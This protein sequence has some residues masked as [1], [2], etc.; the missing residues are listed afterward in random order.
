VGRNSELIRQ[1]TILQQLAARR[2]ATITA[3]ATDLNVTTRTVRRDLT[4]LQ[5]CGFPIYDDV[6]NGTKFWRL[7][8]KTLIAAL[9]RD[10]LTL[11]EFC[12]L[13]FSRALVRG[14]AGT[15]LLVDLQSALDK[16]EAAF[17]A[18][19]KK[20]LDRLP[21]V[22]TAKLPVGTQRVSAAPEF[23][24]RLFDATMAQRVVTMR[25][26]SKDSGREKEYTIHPYRLVYAQNGLYLQAFVPAYADFR[27]FLVDRIRRLSVLEETFTRQAELGSEP[28]SKSMGIHS[29]PTCKVQLLFDRE[30]AAFIKERTWHQSQRVKDRP[31]GTV[32][33][34]LEVC[35]DYALR[36]WILGFGRSIRVL[37]PPSLVEWVLDQLDDARHQY[38]DGKFR[39]VVRPDPQPGLPFLFSR[40]ATA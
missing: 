7:D 28:F 19:M 3:L 1:W 31:D 24:T 20:F 2:P 29:G 12:A 14:I 4:A 40:I 21:V 36:Q 9:S 39:T 32:A 11:P 5:A 15:D 23:T 25:Y 35:D 6:V 17:P 10:A 27:V 26:Y 8:A 18:G 30:V 37:A 38:G 33:V 34:T 13:Y 22:M 16:I